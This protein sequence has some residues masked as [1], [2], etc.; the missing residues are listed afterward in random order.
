MCVG[1]GYN[2]VF[3][4]FFATLSL[5]LLLEQTEG[6][7]CFGGCARLRDVDN[8]KFLVFQILGEL[9]QIVFTNIVASKENG[10]V[11]LIV[12][13]PCKSITQGFDHGTC[14]KVAAADAG[15]HYTFA[16][17]A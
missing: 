17:L 12:H 4:L 1:N 2:H 9:I 8:T 10:G 6:E 5:A 7:G 14:A 16:L 15:Y 13:Q 3:S 11:L